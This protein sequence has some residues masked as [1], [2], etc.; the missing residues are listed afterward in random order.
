[1][2]IDGVFSGGGIKGFA[3]VGGLQVLEEPGFVFQRIAGTSAGSILAALVTAGYTS[4]QIEK[5]F[6]EMDISDFLDRSRGWLQFPFQN[7]YSFIG[8]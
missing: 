4:K 3:L 5:F 2:I 6:R 7:G 8:N 1:M